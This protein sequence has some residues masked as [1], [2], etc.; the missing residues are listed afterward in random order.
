MTPEILHIL[1]MADASVLPSV[2]VKTLGDPN[3][4]FEAVP[5]LRSYEHP[6]ACTILCVRFTHF[7]R[8][9]MSLKD[10]GSAM[11]ATL[12]TDCYVPHYSSRIFSFNFRSAL[13]YIC[14][15]S[16]DSWPSH[17]AIRT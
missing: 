10:I 7:V 14:V 15:V 12:D 4:N 13:I 11:G 3:F 16:T 8:L 9:W 5:T 2:Y 1:T 17:K 6:T